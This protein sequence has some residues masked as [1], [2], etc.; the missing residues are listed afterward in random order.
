MEVTAGRFDAVKICIDNQVES[1][2]VA[3]IFHNAYIFPIRWEAVG[4][5]R[6]L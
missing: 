4:E 1:Q 2:V 6:L 5:G 3:V